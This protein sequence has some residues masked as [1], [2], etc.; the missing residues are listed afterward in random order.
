MTQGGSLDPQQCEPVYPG[1]LCE[2]LGGIM[3]KVDQSFEGWGFLLLGMLS[4]SHTLDT[5][6]AHHVQIKWKA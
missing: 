5:D 3:V 4:N 2:L 1:S 6:W